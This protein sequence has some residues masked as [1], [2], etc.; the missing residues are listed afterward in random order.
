MS[1]IE[2]TKKLGQLLTESLPVLLADWKAAK[3]IL[4]ATFAASED[5]DVRA[6]IT[7]ILDTDS[8]LIANIVELSGRMPAFYQRFQ[9]AEFDVVVADLRPMLAGID[10]TKIDSEAML[11]LL[12]GHVDIVLT[13]PDEAYDALVSVQALV[14]F[15]GLSHHGLLKAFLNRPTALQSFTSNAGGVLIALG[16]DAIPLLGTAREL[17]AATTPFVEKQIAGFET[18]ATQVDRLF[19]LRRALAAMRDHS[20]QIETLART[21]STYTDERIAAFGASAAWLRT[22]LEELS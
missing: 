8:Q 10:R 14:F 21:A 5:P 11:E 6:F 22:R 3:E 1:D 2:E 13:T 7:E 17:I 18:A 4:R 16:S 19:A 15:L 12:K 9:D 20:R